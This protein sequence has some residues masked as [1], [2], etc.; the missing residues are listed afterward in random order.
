MEMIPSVEVI[1]IVL[2]GIEELAV[3][4]EEP[5][6]IFPMQ[7]FC[8]K[9]YDNSHEIIGWGTNEG[10]NNIERGAAVKADA[11]EIGTGVGSM[12]G[13]KVKMVMGTYLPIPSFL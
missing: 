2:F 1:Y 8:Y 6:S 9:I 4:L 3:Q 12:L 13:G 10:K 5:F 11:S 7:G